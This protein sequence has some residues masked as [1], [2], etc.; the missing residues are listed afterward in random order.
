MHWSGM[1]LSF[2][3]MIAMSLFWLV[4]TALAVI[5]VVKLAG[6]SSSSSHGGQ[7]SQ[8]AEDILKQRYARGEVTKEQYESMLSDLRK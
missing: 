5:L 2:L 4:L 3:P 1:G 6:W 8:A 7:R